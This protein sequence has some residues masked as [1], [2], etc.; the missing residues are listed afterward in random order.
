MARASWALIRAFI[1]LSC[2]Q[3]VPS[4]APEI[5]TRLY[6]IKLNS[7]TA[8][9]NICLGFCIKKIFS[10]QISIAEQTYLLFLT[11]KS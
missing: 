3:K 8:L 2:K 10:F 4:F 11:A 6:Y 1:L 5:K 7:S 9:I